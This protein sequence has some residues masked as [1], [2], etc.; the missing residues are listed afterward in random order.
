MH[1]Q[2]E[3][4]KVEKH[5]FPEWTDYLLTG[6]FNILVSTV[7]FSVDCYDD[8]FIGPWHRLQVRPPRELRPE[9]AA[10]EQI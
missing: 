4:Q 2:K 7:K 10:R 8:V 9:G 1:I 6:D 3:L 5:L